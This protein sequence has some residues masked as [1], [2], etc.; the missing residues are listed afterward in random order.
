MQEPFF[1]PASTRETPKD[2]AHLPSFNNSQT[3]AFSSA[4]G[5]FESSYIVAVALHKPM[6]SRK[7]HQPFLEQE[8]AQQRATDTQQDINQIMMARVDSRPPDADHDNG[9]H[10][11]QPLPAMSHERIGQGHHHIGGVQRRYCRKHIGIA[12]DFVTIKTS[13]L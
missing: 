8:N 5:G 9:K 13:I 12:P 11:Y 2:F 4:Y 6:E 3:Q 7:P 1:M 10:R